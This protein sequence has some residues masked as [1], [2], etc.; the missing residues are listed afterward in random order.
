MPSQTDLDQGGS[1]R[2]WETVY[3]GPS[4]GWVRVPKRNMWG[5]GG[6][7]STTITT[8]GTYALDPATNFVQIAVAGAVTI[9]LPS[10]K[11]GSGG[12]GAQPGLDPQTPITIVDI[13][14]N[15]LAHPITIQPIN[16]TETIMGLTQ[17]QITSNYGGFILQ[18]VSR[19]ATWVNAQ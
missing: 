8:P 9:I 14:G 16:N 18:P 3:Q 5:G 15:A 12:Q 17:I 11:L 7:S 10:S 13:A 2:L 19:Q 4:I 6:T 1:Y